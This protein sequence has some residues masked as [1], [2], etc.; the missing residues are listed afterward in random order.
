MFGK[1]D[2]EFLDPGQDPM[3][4]NRDK[5]GARGHR[6]S[7]METSDM[8]KIGISVVVL[9][10]I[11]WWAVG[12]LFGDGDAEASA[13]ATSEAAPTEE[14]NVI[15]I[16]TLPPLET[17][18]ESTLEPAPL[19]PAQIA[20]TATFEA[21]IARPARMNNP[22]AAPSFVG[23][24]TYED[25]CM[26][27]NIGF[28]TSGYNGKPFYLYVDQP[29]E[30][31]PLLQIV[32]VSGIVQQFD[33]CQYPVIFVSELRFFDLEGTPA[34]LAVGGPGLTGTTV[35]S[36]AAVWGVKTTPMPAVKPGQTMPDLGG[37]KPTPTATI[38]ASG[39]IT[40]PR[41]YPTYTPY[42]T[43]P[44]YIPPQRVLP[45]PKN[46]DDDD[47]TAT[48]SPTPIHA[49]IDGRVVAVAGCQA[50]NLAIIKADPD[51]YVYLVFDGA[52]LPDGNPTDYRAM[53]I[54]VLDTICDG[55]AIKAYTV[56]WYK[57]ATGTPTST[58]TATPTATAT[59]TTPPTSTPTATS[60]ATPTATATATTPPTS[61]PTAT[62]T[63]TPTQ[64][65]TTEPTMEPT[66]QPIS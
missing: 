25:G 7:S 40:A 10:L 2:V 31:D 36:S 58:S 20:A 33:D 34:P 12:W 56:T 5:R 18:A 29:F 50:T 65:P 52:T 23:V 45:S 39:T 26:V 19:E 66:T 62:A 53:A 41:P 44:P 35:I 9:A 47:P 27:S 51:Q 8:V 11:G 30:Q 42:P 22:A 6:K 1:R 49:N 17:P 13:P 14:S 63:T 4:L 57:P 60:T 55:Q 15:Q 16:N 64:E 48:P 59:A 28:T 61:T 46:D 21:A 38:T 3:T 37:Y 43:T 32:Q 24:I 54:G